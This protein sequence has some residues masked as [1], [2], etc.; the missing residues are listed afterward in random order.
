MKYLVACLFSIAICASSHAQSNSKLL[1]SW[2]KVHSENL[3]GDGTEPDSLYTR[4]TFTRDEV[5]FSF[6][7]AWDD[8]TFKYDYKG[9]QLQ[10]GFQNFIIEELSDSALTIQ[11]PGYRRI[12]FKSEDVLSEHPTALKLIGEYKGFPLYQAGDTLTPRYKKGN[13]AKVLDRN[14]NGYNLVKA[15]PFR[16]DFTITENG[17]VEDVVVVKSVSYGFDNGMIKALNKTSGNW[18]PATF[19][20]KPVQTRMSYE[21]EYFTTT[22]LG[23]IGK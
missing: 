14:S 1:K 4:Y 3:T 18:N 9:N 15:M 23:R 20:G 10:I 6:F 5:F 17:K 21:K 2:V 19:K 13:F 11:S 22:G 7:P 8:Y 12:M 16:M